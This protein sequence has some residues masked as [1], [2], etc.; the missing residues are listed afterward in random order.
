VDSAQAMFY[1]PPKKVEDLIQRISCILNS[2]QVSVAQLESLVGKCRN[3]AH[4]VPAAALYT[5]AQYAALARAL[6]SS[7]SPVWVRMHDSIQISNELREELSFWL[8][9]RSSLINGGH[10]LSPAHCFL[11]KSHRL[12]NS[13]L[14]RCFLPEIRRNGCLIL[15]AF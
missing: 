9:L 14:L 10:W 12:S 3:M 5:R 13:G 7:A 2:E 6:A 1:V 8:D 11:L 4:A 15:D